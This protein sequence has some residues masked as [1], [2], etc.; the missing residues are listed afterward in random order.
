MP[1]FY[2]DIQYSDCWAS[3]G[4]ITCYHCNGVCFFRSKPYTEFPGTA[5][6][7]VRLGFHR[8]PFYDKGHISD[9]NLFVSAYHGFA[10]LGH[11]HVPEP[12]PFSLS[13]V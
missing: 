13:S 4:D 9:Y 12:K 2:P 10:Q 8:P 1:R 7:L 5:E 3:V 11:E 6:Q